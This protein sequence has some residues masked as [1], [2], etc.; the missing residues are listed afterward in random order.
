MIINASFRS[1]LGLAAHVQRVDTNERVV[2]RDDL[3]TGCALSI[4]EAIADFA[5]IGAAAG[6]SAP[7]IHMSV[8]PSLPLSAKQELSMLGLIARTYGIPDDHPMLVI[9]HVKPGAT[10]R[11][12]H[13]HV[14]VPRAK[15][16]GCLIKDAFYKIKNERISLELEFDFGHPLTPGPNIGAVRERLH[17]ERP[18]MYEALDDLAAPK[19]ENAHSTVVDRNFAHQH[20][21]DL[22]EF[23]ERVFAAWKAG[24][25]AKG[26]S[27]LEPYKILVASGDKALMVV[28]A[29]NGF[30]QSLQRVVNR[31]S[32]R[33][34]APLHLKQHDVE[35]VFEDVDRPKLLPNVRRDAIRSSAKQL[36]KIH[37]ETT[38]VERHL[39]TAL[40]SSPFA[41]ALT[42]QSS[43]SSVEDDGSAARARRSLKAELEAIRRWQ[44]EIVESRKRAADRA[45]RAARIWRSRK[46]ED[47]VFLASAGAALACGA[48]LLMAVGAGV[49]AGACVVAKGR[50]R[51]KHAEYAS[52]ALRQSRADRKRE[53]DQYFASVRQARAFDLK[54]IPREARS[55]VGH[56][57]VETSSGRPPR[58]DVMAALDR[59]KPSLAGKIVSVARH[60]TSASLRKVLRSMYPPDERHA[61]K[62]INAFL[63]EPSRER[64]VRRADAKRRSRDGPER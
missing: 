13:Y 11:P 29:V 21:A 27:A 32:K 8:S 47:F 23:D 50:Q 41:A 5:A 19:R 58:P 12:D 3:S 40:G 36:L 54:D 28:D 31:E 43:P 57:F 22:G 34:G 26:S 35:A 16:D 60:S 37:R 39:G 46:L 30:A 59:V 51:I 18:D 1:K 49:F 4:D 2:L 15:M 44:Q 61:E 48:G 38:A 62:A 63:N 17:A 64:Q 45:W 42:A 52:H 33:Q 10:G 25:F 53:V 6:A 24:A 14:I 55:A 56:I 9:T 20:G 7:L